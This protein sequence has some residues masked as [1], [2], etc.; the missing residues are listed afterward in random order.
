MNSQA[1]AIVDVLNPVREYTRWHSS[2]VV[3]FPRRATC[4]DVVFCFIV[5]LGNT[6]SCFSSSFHYL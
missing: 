2:F 6:R 5:Y 4:S 1:C 3:Y